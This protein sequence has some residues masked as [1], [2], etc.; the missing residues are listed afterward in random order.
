MCQQVIISS[1]R[2]QREQPLSEPNSVLIP[3]AAEP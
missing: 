3:L 2:L 1:K